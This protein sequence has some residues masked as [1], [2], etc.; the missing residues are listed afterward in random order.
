M[1]YIKSTNSTSTKVVRPMN[2]FMIYRLEKQH[3]IVKECPGANHRDISKIVAKWWKEMP[4]EEK[5]PYRQK[6]ERAKEEHQRL[7][8]DYKFS[9]QKRTRKTR[10]YRKRPQNEFTAADFENKR[11]LVAIYHRRRNCKDTEPFGQD[12]TDFYNEKETADWNGNVIICKT[13]AINEDTALYCAPFTSYADNYLRPYSS[14]PYMHSLSTSPMMSCYSQSSIINDS[15]RDMTLSLQP[16]DISLFGFHSEP[17]D[18]PYLAYSESPNIEYS[19]ERENT[20]GISESGSAEEHVIYTD[21]DYHQT[22]EH[23]N[24]YH[25]RWDS[26]ETETSAYRFNYH[27][28]ICHLNSYLPRSF[29]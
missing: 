4:D 23:D 20:T 1:K 24:Y 25:S 10:V 26:A 11:Q 17:A 14:S 22:T 19:D 3:E 8:P 13:Q 12:M 28:P 18:H 29:Y 2:S 6:A 9:P 27:Q 15:E 16:S 5:E 21:N 7:Y